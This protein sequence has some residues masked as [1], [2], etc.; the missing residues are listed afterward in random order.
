MSKLL[1]LVAE[2]E[3]DIRELL[4]FTFQAY[5]FQVIGVSNGEE[6]VKEATEK[7]PD[8][9]LM[10]VRMP[11]RTGFEACQLLK[12]QEKTKHIP[13]VFLSAKGERAD[14]RTGL[15]LGAE[16]YFVKPFVPHELA[17]QIK[18]ILVKHGK[19]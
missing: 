1:I 12:T 7:T 4:V 19:L 17:Q 9:I 3:K 13:V 5:G 8:L 15:A 18:E 6:A 10:D 11:K 14:I 2:D 16:A